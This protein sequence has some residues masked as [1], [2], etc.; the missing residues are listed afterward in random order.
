M[1]EFRKKDKQRRRTSDLDPDPEIWEALEGGP[2]LKRLLDEFYTR[3]YADPRLNHF[4]EGT[5]KQRAAEKQ[6]SFLRQIFTGEKIYF[7]DRP[8][9]SHHWMVISDE[10]FTYRE[11]LF[12]TCLRDHGIPEHLIERWRGVH[13]CFRK[14]IVKDA[15]RPKKMRGKALPFEGYGSLVLDIGSICDGCSGELVPGVEVR[16]HNRTGQTY[17]LECVPGEESTRPAPA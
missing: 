8:R 15:P 16:Y 5:T 1:T 3:V 9:N 7:G 10:L 11:E 17:C 4:F 2:K 12:A 13:E 6:Y 14:Q